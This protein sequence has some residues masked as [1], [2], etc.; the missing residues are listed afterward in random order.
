VPAKHITDAFIRN[1]RPPN[2]G[3]GSAR[4][5]TYFD[6]IERGLALVLVVSY[7][8]T[9]TFRVLTYRNGKPHSQKL[10]SYPQMTV[11]VARDKAR[12][13]FENPERFT[14][15][16][17]VGSFKDVAESWFKRHVEGDRL[18]S[19]AQIR[20]QLERY[21]YPKWRDRKFLEIRR[22]DVND[23]LDF[24]ADNHGRNQAD[25]VLATVRHIMGWYQSRDENYTSP[26]VRGMRRSKPHARDRILNDDEIRQVWQAA[27]QVNDTFAAFIK[28]ALLTAQRREKVAKMQW[29]DL[30]DGE[31]TIRVEHRQKGTAGKLKLPA[32]ALEVIERQHRIA[33]NPHVF[34]GRGKAAF[35]AFS[36]RKKELDEAL[37]GLEPWVIHDLRRTARSLLS[38]AGVR[39]DI[40]E[41]VMGHA[42]GG[43]EG[44]Y[45][46]H[47]YDAEK[48]DA[49]SRLAALLDSIVNPA[50]D[51]VVRLQPTSRA[52]RSGL[53]S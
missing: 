8:G 50:D 10:G 49:L 34:A 22:R 4:Q 3:K 30:A 40:A 19:H 12:Q 13:F 37:P 21:V 33:G 27:D 24:I 48:A 5:A 41:R 32:M 23:L 45:D 35:N 36:Q 52:P 53:S 6:R 17:A 20:R 44:I 1:V 2:P 26:I 31:W 39:P 47:S 9:K 7:G 16:T 11:K 42:I 25:A 46:R 18:R 43:V 15:Q 14:T 38:R 28:M 29:D 51:K